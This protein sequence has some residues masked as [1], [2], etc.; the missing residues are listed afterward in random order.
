VVSGSREEEVG[1]DCGQQRRG[2][3]VGSLGCLLWAQQ[4][5]ERQRLQQAKLCINACTRGEEQMMDDVER[6]E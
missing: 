6:G 3:R 1:I 2:Q 5:G 4:G